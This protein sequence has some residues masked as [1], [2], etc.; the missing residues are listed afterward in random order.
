MSIM[1]SQSASI[2]LS[3]P[4][5]I[6]ENVIKQVSNKQDLF[7]ARTG[8]QDIKQARCKDVFVSPGQDHISNWNTISQDDIIRRIP[9]HAI[10]HTQPNAGDSDGS[11]REGEEVDD[12]DFEDAVAALSRFPNLN[13][14]EIGFTPECTGDRYSSLWNNVVEDMEQREE[15]LTLVFRAIKDIAANN[16]NR[17]I[18]KLAITNLQNCP[19]PDFTSSAL[20]RD[21]MAPL[22]ELHISAT[23]ECNEYGPDHDYT[24]IELRTFPTHL[25]SDWLKPVSANLRALSVYHRTDNWG[26]F[27]GYFDS[28]SCGLSFPKLETL[29]LGYYTLAHDNDIDWILAIPSLRK[30]VLHNC[31]IVSWIRIEPDNMAEWAV[32]THDWTS[33]H[34][35]EEDGRD[36]DFAY[37]GTWSVCLDRIAAAVPNLAD[38]RFDEASLLD[39]GDDE[40]RYG[41]KFRDSCGVR[42][43]P[44]RYV[45][46]DNGT[47]PT[48]WPGADEEGALCSW[49]KGGFPTNMHEET[50]ERDQRSLAG[51]LERL[52]NRR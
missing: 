50:F 34:G 39:Y 15:M 29:C 16:Q 26:P 18:R 51:L 2:L 9:R 30:L 48:P 42:I 24:R 12:E 19:I 31:M 44:K 23:Q 27:P 6:V 20:F 3:L 45:C 37:A 41:L 10:I 47:L 7:I 8:L 25:C 38:F 13:S 5:E 32:H 52:R 17:T 40:P 46:F 4:P 43:F 36:N 1:S 11:E 35:A 22:E 33:L 21:V 14:V 49:L 28:T